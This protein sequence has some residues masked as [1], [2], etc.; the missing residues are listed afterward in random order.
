MAMEKQ[1]SFSYKNTKF[2]IFSLTISLSLIFLTFFSIWV[3]KSDPFSVNQETQKLQFQSTSRKFISK[4]YKVN[5]QIFS[6]TQF[7]KPFNSSKDSIFLSN[8]ENL[9][10]THFSKPLNSS[11]DSIFLT[12]GQNLNQTQFSKPFNSSKDSNFLLNGE[13]LSQTHLSKPL[14]SSKDSIFLLNLDKFERKSRNLDVE[15]SQNLIQTHLSKPLNSSK[16]SIFLLNLDGFERKTSNLDVVNSTIRN[17]NKIKE[18]IEKVCDI[19]NGKWV[20]DESY[21]PMYNSFTCPFIDEGFDCEGNG[22]LD[23]DFMKWK[24]KPHDCHISRYLFLFLFFNNFF[25]L[26]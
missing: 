13:N 10:Q 7:S 14:N 16:D 26:F 3:F 21:N 12:N 9:N 23:K 1:K 25:S 17:V 4:P 19:T 20:F 22:R 18:K 5:T 8:G 15:N 24:W 2:F 6:Q 11:K